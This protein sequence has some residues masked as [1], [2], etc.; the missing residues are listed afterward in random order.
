MD[1]TARR[2]AP[3][4]SDIRARIQTVLGTHAAAPRPEGI[5]RS[6]AMPAKVG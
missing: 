2:V 6:I 3:F 4:P 1:M 5:G